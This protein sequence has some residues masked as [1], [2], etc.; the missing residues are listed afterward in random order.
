MK[1]LD[2]WRG[3]PGVVPVGLGLALA[4]VAIP[5]LLLA[6]GLVGVLLAALVGAV[7]S[8]PLALAEWSWHGAPPQRFDAAFKALGLTAGAL[9]IGALAG[10][11][12]TTPL[13]GAL[14]A[15]VVLLGP[16]LRRRLGPAIVAP[17]VLVAICA[18][19]VWGAA[20]LAAGPWTALWPAWGEIGR[21]AARAIVLGAGLAAPGFGVWSGE[22][23]QPGARR[24]PWLT[25]GLVS[26]GA[27]AAAVGTA[28]RYETG[29]D[30]IVSGV[31]RLLVL[32]A[33]AT[34]LPAAPLVAGL[35]GA[36]WFAWPAAAAVGLWTHSGA[37]LAPGL[38]ALRAVAQTRGVPR[39]VAAAGLAA[40]V[41][42]AIAAW[43]GLATQSAA[44][45]AAATLV[46][47]VWIAGIAGYRSAA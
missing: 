39:A 26:L 5:D 1:R 12:P 6:G 24:A 37:A 41:T 14:V 3:W 38:V 10:P 13:Q 18:L 29:A 7:V 35:A 22:A 47:A 11:L 30:A 28:G 32:F 20:G 4:V 43:P 21:V 9:T 36:L 42:A 40:L 44:A 17:T 33:A 19:L 16:V 27:L 45:A 25:F 8:V 2:A 23:A 34:A 31:V 15:I 46:V